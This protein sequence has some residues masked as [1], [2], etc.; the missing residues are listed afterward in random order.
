MENGSGLTQLGQDRAA[1][2]AGIVVGRVLLPVVLAEFASKIEV[3]RDDGHEKK[4]MIKN[5][6]N[7]L[8]RQ[9]FVR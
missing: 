8:E 7:V 2:A 4:R 3:I 5:E 6:R 1:E 9:Q